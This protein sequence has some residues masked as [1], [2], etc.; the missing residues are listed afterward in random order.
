MS[1]TETMEIAFIRT[2]LITTI[3]IYLGEGACKTAPLT[4][5]EKAVLDKHNELRSKHQDTP[6]LCYAE[7]SGEDITFTSQDW[8]DN[9]AE[10]D[11][12]AHSSTQAGENIYMASYGGN[13]PE[14]EKMYVS[15][16]KG[17]YD[18]IKNWD[19]SLSKSKGV[20]GHFTQIVWKSTSQLNC[21][22]AT[23]N[24]GGY[25]V[26]Q[27]WTPGNYGGMYAEEVA[28][29]KG[30]DDEGDDDEGDDEGERH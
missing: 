11:S 20:T 9:L 12:F 5:A 24:N 17:W 23:S 13:N 4:N 7:T 15:A 16:T 3:L 19:F 30:S 29:L 14:Q 2:L 27:Y 28:P 25:V 26:C 8:A 6:P 18:E 1:T 21:G 22:F 10:T